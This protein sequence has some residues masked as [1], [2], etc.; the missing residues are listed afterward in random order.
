MNFARTT[1][2]LVPVLAALVLTF[3]LSNDAFAGKKRRAAS[4]ANK[5]AATKFCNEYKSTNPG[6]SCIVDKR[7]CPRGYVAERKWKGKGT[8]YSAC[9]KGK[10]SERGKKRRA[11][12]KALSQEHKAAAEKYC[13]SRKGVECKVVKGNIA[14]CGKGWTKAKTF[15]GR[16]DDYLACELTKRAKGTKE[17]KAEAEARCAKERSNGAECEVK[18]ANVL[19]CGGKNWKKV[20]KYGGK[21]KDY[22]VCTRTVWEVNVQFVIADPDFAGAKKWV[23]DS[24]QVAQDLYDADPALVI[25]ATFVQETHRG[26]RDLNNLNFK[27][28]REFHKFM[29]DHFD[30]VAMSRTTGYLQVLVVAPK[31]DKD[32]NTYG[33]RVG[34]ETPGGKSNFPHNVIPFSRKHGPVVMNGSNLSHFA[35]ELGHIQGLK[36]T[37]E[38]YTG[39]SR[40]NK[41][42]KK[43]D[44]GKGDSLRSDGTINVM[45]YD[46]GT[47]TPYL[48][49]C[50]A[51]RAAKKR[52][53]WM[54]TDGKVKYKLVR[55]SR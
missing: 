38:P 20:A 40:C 36:H 4:A 43:G 18:R 48:N 52:K 1:A 28:N 6:A 34:G 23:E 53:Q 50:Q 3:T 33:L 27:N 49:S 32:G 39:G 30:H 37:F 55:G 19:G 15:R 46:R 29:D 35:H 21:G 14:G 41:D 5:A 16:G 31:V 9:V 11:E 44:K 2:R 10:K 25:K 42:Y 51:K 7:T 12:K 22:L 13:A 26:G 54:T 47:R 8:N 24:I 17:N 45:D